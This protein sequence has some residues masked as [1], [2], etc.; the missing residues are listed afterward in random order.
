MVTSDD[1]VRCMIEEYDKVEL[2]GKISRVWIYVCNVNGLGLKLNSNNVSVNCVQ[3]E[4]FCNGV[5]R[6][7]SGF[8]CRNSTKKLGKS[9]SGVRCSDDSLRKLV[10]KQQLLA[11]QRGLVPTVAENEMECSNEHENY[12]HPVLDLASE[13]QSFLSNE[14]IKHDIVGNSCR[15]NS[16]E[17]KYTN[18]NLVG[19]ENFGNLAPLPVSHSH[20]LSI[21]DGNLES[22]R[23]SCLI[24][25]T[26]AGTSSGSSTHLISGVQFPKPFYNPKMNSVVTRSGKIALLNNMNRENIVPCGLD[27]NTVRT[28]LVPFSSSC[29]LGGSV[30]SK[31]TN[32]SSQS[33]I[34]GHRFGLSETRNQRTCLYQIRNHRSNL[35]ET[36]NH[37]NVRLE[38]RPWVGKYYPGLKSISNISKQGMAT[39]SY[40]RTSSKP[41]SASHCQKEG[42]ART[43]EGGLNSQIDSY[44]VPYGKPNPKECHLV[45]HGASTAMAEQTLLSQEALEKLSPCTRALNT[46]IDLLA[47]P[48]SEQNEALPIRTLYNNLEMPMNKQEFYVINEAP[49]LM[50]QQ[51]DLKKPS[52]CTRALDTQIDLLTGSVSKQHEVSNQT[53][54]SNLEIPM[55]EQDSYDINEAPYLMDQHEVGIS[56]ALGCNGKFSDVEAGCKSFSNHQNGPCTVQ[57]GIA[58]CV[59]LSL[60][61][62]SLSSSE[63][64]EPPPISSPRNANFSEVLLKPQSKPYDLMDDEQFSSAPQ[65]EKSSG[66]ASLS[67]PQNEAK[68][69]KDNDEKTEIE[70]DP[71]SSLSSNEKVFYK[72]DSQVS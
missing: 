23:N 19:S 12:D 63:H 29:E 20:P 50:D 31:S 62:L 36:G 69:G 66:V 67:P 15:R 37:R 34:R 32:G 39:R 5:M 2:E 27:C 71:Q 17:Y 3:T 53:S 47:S 59:D 40:Y 61:N 51:E 60:H 70:Q 58:S 4:D 55:N 35:I 30:Y 41:W 49:Y 38:S 57:G 1:D 25:G 9:V 10:L 6:K 11:K 65:V 21:N 28:E 7:K 26:G 72:E 68:M 42:L 13:S 56:T 24:L 48:S 43:T 22:E 16:L 18:S 64:V 33:R 14:T 52:P 54:Y 46:Q 44:S 8:E 45:Y